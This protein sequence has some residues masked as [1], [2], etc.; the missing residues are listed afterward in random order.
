MAARYQK[1]RL[2]WP[3]TPTQLINI[4]EMFSEIYTDLATHAIDVTVDH[5]I[6]ILP[7]TSGG[8]GTGTA[9][10]PGSVVFAGPLGVYTQDN[11]NFFW[12][13]TNNRLGL[14]TNAPLAKL[15]VRSAL[16]T[17]AGGI[18]FGFNGN[19]GFF[20]AGAG[21]V[22]VTIGGSTQYNW[23]GA[24]F[25][26]ITNESF[27]LVTQGNLAT[28]PV[29]SFTNDLNTGMYKPGGAADTLAFT[30][31]GVERLRIDSSGNVRVATSAATLY[32]GNGALFAATI[33]YIGTHIATTD[34]NR[35]VL[36]RAKNDNITGGALAFDGL[37]IAL[38]LGSITST[39]YIAYGGFQGNDTFVTSFKI[40]P[41]GIGAADLDIP[42]ANSILLENLA[43]IDA[44]SSTGQNVA[45]L[46]MT[47]TAPNVLEFG[48]K[49]DGIVD[50]PIQ[51]FINSPTSYYAWKT[52]AGTELARLT[53][54][55]D[56]T[57]LKPLP[58][59][60]GGSGNR[61]VIIGYPAS[62]DGEDGSD[63]FPGPPGA[64][65]PTGAAGGNGPAGIGLPGADGEDG[66]DGYPGP[67]GALGATGPQ[68]VQGPAG[69]GFPGYDGDDGD[70]GYPGP[71]GATGPA[72]AAGTPGTPGIIGYTIPG[73]DGE[74]GADGMP[75]VPWSNPIPVTR[76]RPGT[77]TLPSITS[78]VKNDS[79]IYFT[80][81]D[82]TFADISA[83]AVSISY[84]GQRIATFGSLGGANGTEFL[85]L[86]GVHIV[87]VPATST[88]GLVSLNNTDA[89]AIDPI[90]YSPRIRL[91][92]DA[93]NLTTSLNNELS[94]I[95]EVRPISS[96]TP[97]SGSL[98]WAGRNNFSAFTDLMSLS[99]AGDLSLPLKPLS[100]YNG[101]TGNRNVVI[102][103]PTA[104][105]GEDG[106]D[107]F[108]GI[109][110]NQGP[111]GPA[112]A[113]GSPGIR[114]FDG[115]DGDDGWNGPPGNQGIQGPTGNTGPQGLM[116]LMGAMGYDGE[117]GEMGI[118]GA[119]GQSA[120]TNQP[121]ANAFNSAAQAVAT[122]SF[123][124]LN[125]D[126]ET[127]D[128]A[129]MH[130]LVT[131]NSRV[132]IQEA[133]TYIILARARF[134]ASAATQ[135]AIQIIK[136]GATALSVNS[137][138]PSATINLDL[139]TVAIDNFVVGD[140]VENQAFQNSGGNVNVGAV[141]AQ[142]AN[143]LAAVKIG[144]TSAIG[145][146]PDLSLDL[147]APGTD[148]TVI[149]GY[150]AIVGRSYKIASGKKLTVG[151][152]ARMRIL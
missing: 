96:V 148:E 64:P 118:P 70:L 50:F 127:Y 31:A 92:A 106:A 7:V 126:S 8:T 29:Y 41:N 40:I 124:S 49:Y 136:N 35:E 33:P 105:D 69:I 119:P 75:I 45:V 78:D 14:G 134:A 111:T 141:V 150:S 2:K 93:W 62:G 19:T 149:S 13:D 83:S 125:L 67:A 114:G 68:G 87:M 24:S 97:I 15:D 6:G 72:G 123:V 18:V 43:K 37:G 104:S 32:T 53:G 85:T 146:I 113:A 21:T 133:G 81:L 74:D 139:E 25:A 42:A 46:K 152:G 73:I 54:A 3:L 110:G 101:G 98:F 140:Y 57:F 89:T 77:V 22:R 79:G 17:L 27:A 20:E 116:G 5:I 95:Q 99:T 121:K 56:W 63:G 11:A 122:G 107:G 84:G 112:G 128:T 132:I 129:G 44:Y 30:T 80:K 102:G 16:G 94:I 151:S 117:D 10:T 48:T 131:N 120:V 145:G 100:P 34:N 4:D 59:Y 71:P 137:V 52:V 51:F 143:R 38:G 147:L 58:M 144:N 142:A 76:Y 9:F 86:A 103:F 65:G 138:V 28:S 1:Y 36:F 130:D 23:T 39:G 61:D 26:S 82:G 12:D 55:G 60:Q 66:A 88:D 108:M 91:R 115:E 47:N 109:P 90:V 135:V